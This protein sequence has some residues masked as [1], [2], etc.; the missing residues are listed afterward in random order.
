MHMRDDY[1]LSLQYLDLPFLIIRI[2]SKCFLYKLL[3]SVVVAGN[4]LNA[5]A[6]HVPAYLTRTTPI[7]HVLP[8]RSLF[9]L[10]SKLQ[11]LDFFKYSHFVI[12]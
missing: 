1:V 5:I 7:F 10:H 12:F 8:A 2:I 3:N 4:C 11:N 9:M 6:F